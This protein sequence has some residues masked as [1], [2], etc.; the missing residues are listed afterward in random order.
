M[1]T[2]D[3]AWIRSQFP[4]LAEQVNSCAE[5]SWLHAGLAEALR[6]AGDP[7]RA[8]AHAQQAIALA[9][10]TDQAHAQRVAQQ[11]QARVFAHELAPLVVDC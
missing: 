3:I 10:V 6:Q 4:A 1:T 11:V 7:N 5:Q 9:E 8:A 2:L